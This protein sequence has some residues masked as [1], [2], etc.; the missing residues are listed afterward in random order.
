M[1]SVPY[2]PHT[3]SCK[4]RIYEP[5]PKSRFVVAELASD[6][7]KSLYSRFK[8]RQAPAPPLHGDLD[9][10]ENKELQ[11]SN[12]KIKKNGGSL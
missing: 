4:E 9:K 1:L 5:S 10:S 2:S 8:G 12:P 3:C 11:K 6:H 7:S